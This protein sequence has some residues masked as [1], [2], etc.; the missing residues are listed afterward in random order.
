[1]SIDQCDIGRWAK[2]LKISLLFDGRGA[3]LESTLGL[4][5]GDLDMAQVLRTPQAR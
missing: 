4:W 3:T 5:R 1:M 2:I